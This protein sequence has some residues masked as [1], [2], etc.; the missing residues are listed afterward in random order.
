[1]SDAAVQAKTGKTWPEWFEILDAAG[2]HDMDHRSIARYAHEKLGI[3]GWWAQMVT[4]GYER[5]RARRERHERHD[6]Y[7]ITRS[8]TIAVT[9]STLYRAW[10]DTRARD[11]WLANGEIAIRKATAD[12]CLRITWKPDGTS[13]EVNFYSKGAGKAQVTV[14]H[15]KLRDAR[16]AERMRAYWGERLDRLKGVLER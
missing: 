15:G 7:Q 1:M 11:R 10:K 8:K 9:L 4:V 12:K 5:A 6:G 16:Q 14:Q 2:A 13:V 3:P